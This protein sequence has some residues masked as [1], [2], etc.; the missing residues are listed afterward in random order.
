MHQAD[1]LIR[2]P[3][4]RQC[5]LGERVDAGHVLLYSLVDLLGLSRFE[6]LSD[7]LAGVEAGT[8]ATQIREREGARKYDDSCPKK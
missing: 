7:G 2:A 6:R 8:P 5:P 1:R 3:V 4:I